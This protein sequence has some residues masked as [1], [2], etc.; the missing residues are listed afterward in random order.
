MRETT[1]E[2]L[3]AESVWHMSVAT[4]QKIINLRSLEIIVNV[5]RRGTVPLRGTVENATISNDGG[6]VIIN[7][8]SS[9]ADDVLEAA[10]TLNTRSLRTLEMAEQTAGRITK[11]IESLPASANGGRTDDDE[12][13]REKFKGF[14]MAASAIADAVIDRAAHSPVR[15]S[16]GHGTRSRHQNHLGLQSSA[17]ARQAHE[18]SELKKFTQVPKWTH[19]GRKGKTIYCPECGGATHV[20]NFAW[21]ALKCSHCEADVE[22]Y[23]WLRYMRYCP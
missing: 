13:N 15:E 2:V 18:G 8:K 1:K 21:S 12:R 11:M 16:T 7:L 22:K 17:T 3:S 9:C 19:A 20:H 4:I 5:G 14:P 23:H 6:T 10:E